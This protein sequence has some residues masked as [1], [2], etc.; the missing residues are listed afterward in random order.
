[1][2]LKYLRTTRGLQDWELSRAVAEKN[3]VAKEC[4][5]AFDE[6]I[7]AGTPQPDAAKEFV[8]ILVSRVDKAI[9]RNLKSKVLRF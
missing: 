5:P 3:A 6:D 1:V 9:G 2:L 4:G 8:T 7:A